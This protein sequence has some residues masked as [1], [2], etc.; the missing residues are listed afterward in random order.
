MSF[1]HNAARSLGICL[2]FS[3]ALPALLG[4]EYY[5]AE[6]KLFDDGTVERAIYQPLDETPQDVQ[7]A[8]HWSTV[9][10]SLEI[11]HDD[12]ESSITGL[13][14][15]SNAE[16]M[17]HFAAWGRFES[18]AAIPN[19]LAIGSGDQKARGEL[20]RESHRIDYVFVVEHQWDETLTDIVT[21]DD[22]HLARKELA[23]FV[24]PLLSDIVEEALGDDYDWT[25]MEE[26]LRTEGSEWFFEITDVIYDLALRDM[27][28]LESF[29]ERVRAG[30]AKVSARHGLQLGDAHDALSAKGAKADDSRRAIENFTIEKFHKLVH[31]K[32]GKPIDTATVRQIVDSHMLILGGGFDENNKFSQARAK[33]CERK[34][35]GK[36]VVK[37]QTAELLSRVFGLYWGTATRMF[38]YTL[39]VP[40]TVVETSGIQLSDNKV[41][42]GFV[43]HQ[44]Y[45]AGY[46]MTC[47]SL[48]PQ[49]DLQERVLGGQPLKNR[50][51]MLR[52]ISL[53]N[54]QRELLPI[55]KKC[56]TQASAQPLLQY[57][58]QAVEDLR[59]AVVVNVDE[60]KQLRRVVRLLKL[61]E[62]PH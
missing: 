23:D 40:G 13:P 34:W 7:E 61:L 15:V 54:R 18:V 44:A 4:C 2:S 35:G 31:D 59:S 43:A 32:N 27:S 20:V 1:I 39:E 62:L 24:I 22:M 33:V 41:E 50:E 25:A 3:I 19:H 11:E 21:L 46:S 14:L 6:T 53:V 58:E 51:A 52:F 38:N 55:L 49:S 5:R 37:R 36:E 42:W 26:W 60:A 56:K 12:W 28:Q 47:R 10:Y 8:K 45:P 48:S 30:V 17:T 16:D 29:E 57:H 9:T